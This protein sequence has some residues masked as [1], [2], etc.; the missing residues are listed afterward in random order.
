MTGAAINPRQP[1]LSPV[2]EALRRSPVSLAATAVFLL[3]GEMTGTLHPGQRHPSSMMLLHGARSLDHPLSVL[4]SLL[5]APGLLEHLWG[6]LTLLTLG[7]LAERRLGSARYAVAVVSTH[8]VASG[9][10]VLGAWV[11]GGFFPAW[12][13]AFLTMAY[14]GP[15]L[16]VVGA[17]LVASATLPTLWRR[18]VR[19]GSLALF[20]TMVLFYGGVLAVL[21]LAATVAGLVLGHITHPARPRASP[22]G[23]VHEARVLASVVVAATGLGPLL[24]TLTPAPAGPFAML[25]Y[26]VADVRH[27]RPSVVA[28]LCRDAPGTAGCAIVHATLHPSVGATL[29]AILPALLLLVFADGLRRGRRMAWVGALAMEG[30]LAGVAVTDYVLTLTDAGPTLPIAYRFDESPVLMLTQLVLPSL[31]PVT[32]VVVMLILR[33]ALFAVTAPR[34]QTAR[35]GIRLAALVSATAILYVGVGQLAA[36][37][38]TLAP[39]PWSLV[40]DFPLRLVPTVLTIGVSPDL[41]PTGPLARVLSDWTGIALW[42]GLAAVVLRSFRSTPAGADQR[43]RATAMLLEHG[44][45]SLAWMGLWAGNTY[46]FSPTGRSYVAY[47]LVRGVALTLADPVGPPCERAD[48]VHRFAA[49]C[50]STGAVPCFYSASAEL[51]SLCAED[52]WHSVQIAEETVLPL[53]SLAF[54]G[55]KFQDLRTALNRADREA[56]HVEWLDYRTASRTTTTQIRAI[57][58]DWVAKQSLPE[59]GFTLGG[60][61]QLDD[62]HVRCEVVVDDA[63]LVHAV[64]SWLPIFQGGDVIGWT[65]DVMRRRTGAFAHSSELLIARAALDLQQQGYSILSLSGAPLARADEHATTDHARDAD[66]P[67]RRGV[68]DRLLDQVGTRLE[69]VYGFRS[70]LKFK[71]KFTPQYRPMYLIY[72]DAASLPTIGRA[73]ARAYVPHAS[74]RMLLRVARTIVLGRPRTARPASTRTR[75]PGSTASTRPRTPRPATAST[76][77]QLDPWEHPMTD[78]TGTPIPAPQPSATPDAAG[79]VFLR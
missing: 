47:R 18:R 1:R 37:Q 57:S 22:V 39:T 78:Q 20:A 45:G 63:G 7:V 71:A 30:T 13:R 31:V 44:G 58:R 36:G 35:L 15:V 48:T 52:G 24:A 55:K 12:A 73:V 69:P 25:G 41:V 8:V 19:V 74:P 46:W 72:A 17:V 5:W 26:L 53:G 79:E 68:L 3:I 21:L 38:W 64:A 70:L 4:S 16:G 2:G 49:F 62:P 67:R 77:G 56:V 60:L 6:T 51:E 43:G 40:A 14:G 59:M 10:V 11:I 29:M 61:D 27:A 9:A 50:E 54:T 76:H 33:R 28:A 65:L 75:P 23:S 32:A 66:A 42:A 34:R